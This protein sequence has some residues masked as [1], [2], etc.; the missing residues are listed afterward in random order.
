MSDA[1]KKSLI[2]LSIHTLPTKARQAIARA[3]VRA[4]THYR[5][6]LAVP[7]IAAEEG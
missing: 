6:S 3:L 7:S 5:A 4:E 1:A 2:T